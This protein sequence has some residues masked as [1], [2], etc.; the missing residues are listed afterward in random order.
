MVV[1]ALTIWSRSLVARLMLPIGIMLALVCLLGL[2]GSATRGRL[3]EARG[4][5]D[6]AAAVRVE[7]IEIRSLSRSLQRDALNLIFEPDE[8]ELAVIH[9]KVTR[10]LKET[11]TLLATFA[12]SSASADRAQRT[13]YLFGQAVVLD[14]LAAVMAAAARGRTFEALSGFRSKVRPAERE[15]SRIADT[16]IAAQAAA[17]ERLAQR[18]RDLEFQESVISVTASV[19]LFALAA[20]ATSIIATR[21]V[22]RPLAEIERAL[23]SVAEGQTE[24][25]TPHTGRDDEIGRMARAI[26][27]FRSS[28]QERERL[29]RER[30][31]ARNAE[32]LRERDRERVQRRDE[33]AEADRARRIAAA[34]KDLHHDVE[35]ALVRLRSSARQLS[36]TST[37]L[38]RHSATSTRELDEVKSS[39]ARAADG[40]TDIAASA[41]QF[42][43]AIGDSSEGT[44]RTADLTTDA[45]GHVSVLVDRM[46]QV[47]R[48]ATTVGTVVDLIGGI[49]KQTNLLALNASIEAARAGEAGQGF[50]VVA[51]E[52]KS[53]AE[54]S[55]RATDDIAV[56]VTDVQR[57][58]RE[59]GETLTRVGDMIA[60]LA[61]GSDRLASTIEE[62][63]LT[64]KS[65][66]S[67]ITTAA[68][69][70]E[71]IDARVSEV[72]T[73]ATEVE[74]LAAVVHADALLVEETAASIGVAL[75]RFSER[76]STA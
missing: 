39:V 69:D 76:L 38:T 14:Q 28:V 17:V 43:S 74:R 16:M 70:L 29:Q 49:A 15:A 7:L 8:R 48:D 11:R 47:Q 4:S 26:E 66:N 41:N 52:V 23:G 33:E 53:L 58:A 68:S 57:A 19:V 24:G 27:I 60:E 18:T 37:E 56:Q 5:A 34:A 54:Q 10:R 12:R 13:R 71:T 63:A 51:G 55:A 35:A 36:G 2:I 1:H 40:A 46:M 75:S 32:V 73:A 65:I 67:N 3:R 9:E 64:G 31:E 72:A 42:M 44:R 22:A 59:A 20:I 25:Q 21:S 30:A 50:A 62:Q 61:A 45:T 6:Q